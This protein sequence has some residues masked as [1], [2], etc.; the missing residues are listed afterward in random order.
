[1][2]R[3]LLIALSIALTVSGSMLAGNVRISKDVLMDKIKGAW[4]GQTIGCTFGGPTEFRYGC[5]M[6]PDSVEIKWPEHYIKSYFENG[7]GLYD[8]VYMDLTFVD[9]FAREGLDAPIESFANAFAHAAYPL[10]HA[11][12]EG[13]ANI[14]EGLMPPESG[15]WKNNPH[16]DDIDFQIEA[17]YAGIMAPGMPNAASYYCDGIGHMMNY[18]DGWY[19]GVYVAACYSLAFVR[20][21]IADVVSEALGVLPARS[22]YARCIADV[23]KCHDERPDDWKYAW[24]MVQDNYADEEDCPDEWNSTFRID[25]VVNGAYIVIGLLYGDEDFEK[26]IEIST[27]CGQDSDCNP[28]SAGGILATLKG[29]SAIPAKFMDRLT[30]VE[31]T[32]FA[33][34]EISLNKV[35]GLSY[36]QAL[37]VI[38][39]N[40]GKVRKNKVKIRV[41]KPEPVRYEKSYGGVMKKEII[42]VDQHAFGQDVEFSFNG[43]GVV[44]GGRLRNRQGGDYEALVDVYIDGELYKTVSVHEEYYHGHAQIFQAFDLAEGEHSVKLHVQNPRKDKQLWV[45]RAAIYVPDPSDI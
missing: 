39:R 11:N 21:S 9:V 34:T 12:L 29:Y 44:L 28:A 5:M 1:M 31:D 10:W 22:R 7:P 2:R 35:Y 32:D 27:R 13:R 17:D 8:D 42:N 43:T 40:G 18:G 3:R 6:I 45:A 23:I 16:A 4:A 33:Y 26:T 30:E 20:N 19:G 41:Q 36:D 14:L 15:H 25:A 38:A 37:Q 24:Q